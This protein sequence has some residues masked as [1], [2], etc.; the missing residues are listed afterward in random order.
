MT[1]TT[2][3]KT[4]AARTGDH[5]AYPGRLP[6]IEGARPTAGVPF[7][8]LAQV[9]LRKM[10]DTRAGRWLLITIG[11]V[12]AAILTILFF[13]EGGA[14]GYEG[15]F[16]ATSMPL[17]ILVPIVGILAATAEW[18]QRTGLTTFAL[19]PRRSRVVLAKVVAS[20]VA[21]AA[22][23]VTAVGLAALVN[24]LAVT[25]RGADSSW[26]LSWGLL[27]GV[28][29]VLVL[30]LAQGVGFGLALLNTP[31]AI[32]A[33]LVLPTAWSFVTALVR[34]M[35]TAGEWLDLGSATTPLLEGAAM[36]AK[37]WAQVGTASALWVV[38]PLAI[39]LWRVTRSEVK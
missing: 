25:A 34:P 23:L 30:N 10:V 18:S 26:S 29:L 11:V 28:A 16:G 15:Y 22:S 33:Y 7:T 5:A 36:H 37:D 39:G 13:V 24:L 1:T 3:P 9:E 20:L 14:H 35:R 32:V 8:R 27:A 2:E 4:A 12:I 19:E 21:A 17:M 31:A 38:V 6:R